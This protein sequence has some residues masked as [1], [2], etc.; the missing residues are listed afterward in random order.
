VIGRG[1]FAKVLLTRLKRTGTA[2]GRFMKARHHLFIEK[3]WVAP[4]P[5]T[6]ARSGF[7]SVRAASRR[8]HAPIPSRLS[9]AGELFAMK[10]MSKA[11]LAKREMAHTAQ[12]GPSASVGRSARSAVVS[13]LSALISGDISATNHEPAYRM[14]ALIGNRLPLWA[15]AFHVRPSQ[16]DYR[17]FVP[18]VANASW[19]F[20]T[21]RREL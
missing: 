15:L 13:Q 19:W 1:S 4:P 5:A 11:M 14:N 9:R 8:P 20:R 12:V 18:I 21:R 6:S 7:A 17:R 10:S 3:N 2:D 16:T